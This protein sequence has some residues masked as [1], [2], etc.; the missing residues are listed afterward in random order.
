[1]AL[2]LVGAI[3][4]GIVGLCYVYLTTQL[5][6]TGRQIHDMEIELKDLI[7]R[8]EAAHAKISQLS[9]RTVLQRRLNE[10]F[11]KMQPITDDHI[12]RVASKATAGDETHPVSNK[13][14]LR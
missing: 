9:S 2:W 8:N 6:A 12:V 11:I 13:G 3:F 14:G 7:G 1:M 5:H 10:G 4:A